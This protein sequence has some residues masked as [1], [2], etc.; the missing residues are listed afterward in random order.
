MKQLFGVKTKNEFHELKNVSNFSVAQSFELKPHYVLRP[1]LWMQGQSSVL[2]WKKFQRWLTLL[3]F[4]SSFTIFTCL[5][6]RIPQSFWR[7]EKQLIL[8]ISLLIFSLSLSLSLNGTGV[9][10][11]GLHTCKAGALL[12][13]PCLQSILF[14]LFWRWGLKNY[15]SG[16]ASNLRPLDVNLPSS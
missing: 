14:W 16:L 11:S 9:L 7:W 1:F 6:A 10:N 8:F 13:E 15:L 2:K 5:Q 3:F 4:K 12:L